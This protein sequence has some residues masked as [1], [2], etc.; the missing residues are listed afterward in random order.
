[1]YWLVQFTMYIRFVEFF[2]LY[3]DRAPCLMEYFYL[4]ENEKTVI[5]ELEIQV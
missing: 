4:I 2:F 5:R 1:M 3:S